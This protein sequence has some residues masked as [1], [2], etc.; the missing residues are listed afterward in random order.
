MK[1]LTDEDLRMNEQAKDVAAQ[2]LGES[3]LAATRC[4]QITQA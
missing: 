2:V 3:V 4:E 1:A